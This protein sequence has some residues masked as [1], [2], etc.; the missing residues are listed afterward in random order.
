[1]ENLDSSRIREHIRQMALACHVLATERKNSPDNLIPQKVIFKDSICQGNGMKAPFQCQKWHTTRPSMQPKQP[2]LPS[3]SSEEHF[4][5]CATVHIRPLRWRSNCYCSSPSAP[6][7][8]PPSP[9]Q[10]KTV[11]RLYS[12]PG[13][14]SEKK[15]TLPK[16]TSTPYTGHVKA[17]NYWE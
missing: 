10:G 9:R 11:N 14:A 3:N 4:C 15:S 16:V 1:M 12:L 5:F 7:A 8:H 13:A 17:L 6:L 2:A